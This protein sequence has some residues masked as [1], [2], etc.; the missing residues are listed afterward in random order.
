MSVTDETKF[1]PQMRRGDTEV[2]VMLREVIA[3]M[4]EKGHDPVVQL[5]G[6]LL[7]GDPTYITSHRN[8]RNLIRSF[9]R[10]RV[11]EDLIALYIRESE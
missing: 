10:D 5:A 2:S 6:Y 9:E 1:Y 11:M 3:A 7:S 4:K 8:A